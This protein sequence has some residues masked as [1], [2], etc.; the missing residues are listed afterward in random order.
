ME[1]KMITQTDVDHVTYDPYRPLTR[2]EWEQRIAR[3]EE[4]FRTGHVRNG[5]DVYYEMKKKYG[6]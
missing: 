2:E 4:D 5:F 3:A 1:N 6:L